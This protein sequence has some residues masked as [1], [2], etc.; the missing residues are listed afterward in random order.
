MLRRLHLLMFAGTALVLTGFVLAAYATDVLGDS[1]LDTVDARF[2]IR[3]DLEPQADVVIAGIDEQ[4]FTELGEQ[5]PFPRSLHAEAI[6]QLAKDGARVI[7]YDVQFTEA[8]TVEDDQALADSIARAGNVVLATTVVDERG[9]TNVFGGDDV[10]R[11]LRARAAHAGYRTDSGRVVRRMARELEKLETFPVATVERAQR[12]QIRADDFPADPAWID[13]HGRSNVQTVSFHRVVRGDFPPGTF[14]DRIVVVGATAPSLQ[15]VHPTSVSGEE[16]M[17]G[18]EI[19]ANSI[20]TIL[21]DFPLREAPEWVT[22]ALILLFGAVAPLIAIRFGPLRAALIGLALAGLYFAFV[23]LLFDAG[24]IVGFV[25]PEASLAFGIVGA[26]G[27]AL[28]VDAFERARVRDL[29][30]RFVPEPV[31]DEVLAHVD[32]DLRL[33]GER[34]VVTVLFSDIRGFT[35]YSETRPP[36]QVIEV[37][38]HYLTTMTDAI[39]G[40]G[41]TLVAFIGDGILGVFGA[42]IPMDDHADRAF[43]AAREVAGPALDEFNEW[44]RAEG[45][46]DGFR[47]GVGLNSG[48]V[49]AG[50]VGS[51]RRLEY[52]VIG[53]TANTAS[54]IEGMTKG[55]PSMVLL[56]DSV[57]LAFTREHPPLVQMDTAPVRGRKAGVVLWAPG[58]LS[59]DG[60]GDAGQPRSRT[61]SEDRSHA[62]PPAPRAPR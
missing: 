39:L 60:R 4:S 25:Y 27:V 29:F 37:L 2:A 32:E 8:S 10:V 42:P 53:D 47:I 7:A 14:R 35:S 50:N 31:V 43:A 44:M 49:M 23:Q 13:F 22:I 24:V 56:S 58:P 5:W 20:S 34:R 1:E 62:R 36:E 59:P 40:H 6:D 52:T 45:H 26:L 3:G 54:R 11:S 51:E 38:N 46:G 30:S 55:G 9:R 33:G 21:R 17:Y 15:D 48:P 16:F 12:R 61:S 57:R 41:G 18:V 28:V 19:L